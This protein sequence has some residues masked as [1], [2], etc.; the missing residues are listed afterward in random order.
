MKKSDVE[1]GAEV[2]DDDDDDDEYDEE[3]EADKRHEAEE[4]KKEEKRRLERIDSICVLIAFIIIIAASVGENVNYTSSNKTNFTS[5]GV[6]IFKNVY[7]PD[8]KNI[9]FVPLLQQV[10][11]KI[12]NIGIK[13]KKFLLRS[14]A[15][16]DTTATVLF[17][18]KARLRLLP[19]VTFPSITPRF[20]DHTR[21][22][23]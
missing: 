9:T 11:I 23:H 15:T 16:S 19:T 12:T 3:A 5:L 18:A 13:K 8:I 2:V 21:H 6:V 20:R 4:K 7:Y 10:K 14:V 17:L 22:D 1:T